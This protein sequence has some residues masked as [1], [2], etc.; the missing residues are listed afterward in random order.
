MAEDDD[1]DD[2]DEIWA[3]MCGHIAR[4][5]GISAERTTAILWNADGHTGLVEAFDVVFNALGRKSPYG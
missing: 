5:A 1:T 3:Q 2:D 4:R